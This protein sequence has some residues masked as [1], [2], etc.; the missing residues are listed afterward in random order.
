MY[1]DKT[2]WTPP[3]PIDDYGG[4]ILW[5]SALVTGRKKG[6]IFIGKEKWENIY[7]ICQK[8]YALLK[9]II[10]HDKEDKIKN[11]ILN[12]Q[13]GRDECKPWRGIGLHKPGKPPPGSY[14]YKG[15]GENYIKGN[16]IGLFTIRVG[17]KI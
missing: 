16:I 6:D 15:W 4:E 3:E 1:E 10:T 14:Y 13:T 12:N 8:I 17:F 2:K 9:Y 7:D 5:M 11:K